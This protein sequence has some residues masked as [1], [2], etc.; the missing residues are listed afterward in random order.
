MT[1]PRR[2]HL[3]PQFYMRSF[4]D[5]QG[6]VRVL[7]RATGK[8]FTTGT[9]NVFVERDYYTISSVES[10]EDHALIESIYAQAES[11]AFAGPPR[12]HR[13][14]ACMSRLGVVPADRMSEDYSV[15]GDVELADLGIVG[16]R[17]GLEDRH[18]TQE[19]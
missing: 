2:H 17:A 16:A 4:A 19:A 6:R 9:T 12:G 15:R 1:E 3:V 18:R 5:S 14:R 8:E 10:E 13:P 11:V 7:E